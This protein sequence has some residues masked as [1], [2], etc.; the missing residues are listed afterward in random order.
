VR[1]ADAVAAA[2]PRKAHGFLFGKS[3]KVILGC[4]DNAAAA[5]LGRVKFCMNLC[6]VVC[7]PARAR[8]PVWRDQGAVPDSQTWLLLLLLLLLSAG[9]SSVG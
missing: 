2:A 4:A 1:R 6:W 5:V 3:D 8:L 7:D 9:P